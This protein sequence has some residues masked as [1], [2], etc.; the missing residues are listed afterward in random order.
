MNSRIVILALVALACLAAAVA[1][2]D[3]PAPV[4][5]TANPPL[6]ERLTRPIH[7]NPVLDKML[8]GAN[9]KRHLHGLDTSADFLVAVD[10]KDIFVERY[11]SVNLAWPWKRLCF[12]GAVENQSILPFGTPGD[13]RAEVRHCIDALASDGTG[14]VLASCHALQGNTPLENILAMYDE[15]WTYGSGRDGQGLLLRPRIGETKT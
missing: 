3:P 5:A 15:A 12:H 4:P 7:P 2:G 9:L 1:V 14:Y 11:N 13:V 6:V 8:S 10:G